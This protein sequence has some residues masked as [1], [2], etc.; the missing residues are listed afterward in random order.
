MELSFVDQAKIA[1]GEHVAGYV[2]DGMTIGVGTGSTAA[3]AIESIGRRIRDLGW[4]VRGVPTSFAAERMARRCGIDVVTLDDADRIHLSFDGADEVTPD[5]QLIKGRGAA[6]TREKVVASFADRFIVLVDESK[7]V[8]RL[9]ERVPVPIE[10]VP[11]ATTPV[12][13]A[14]RDLGGEPELRQGK[15]KDGPV[16]TDQGLWIVDARFSKIDH[17]HELDAAIHRIPGVLEHGMFLD[18]A[19]EV[20]VGTNDGR[21]RIVE[22]PAAS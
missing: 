5:L 18:L 9:G 22:R 21:V 11:M 12:M 3:R 2:S 19:D 14:I 1:V 6:H 7:L 10:V 15:A 16:V 17:P 13:R 8:R 20:L 4:T